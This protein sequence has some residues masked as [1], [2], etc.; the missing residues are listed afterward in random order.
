MANQ[1]TT[2]GSGAGGPLMVGV[3]G[4]RGIVGGSL[5]ADVVARYA[6]AWATMVQ[7][8]GA[9]GNGGEKASATSHQPSAEKRRSL[10]VVGRDGRAGGEAIERMAVDALT[11]AG[12]DVVRLGVAMTPT[13][14]V[15]VRARDAAGGMVVT[16]SHNPGEW[17]GL[18]P[19]TPEGSAPMPEVARELVA[20][21]ERGG[22][23][24]ADQPGRAQ[25][26]RGA[27]EFHVDR[28]LEA[29][30]RV[31]PLEKIRARRMRVVVDSVNASGSRGA[32]LLMDALGCVLTHI[33]CDETGVFP[34][35]PEP[36]EENLR[37]LCEAVRVEGADVGFAQDPDADRLAVV[38]GDGVYIGEEYTLVVA[39]L[40]V[41]E[42][43]SAAE[44]HRAV[45]AANLSTS[46][47]VDD[48]AARFEATVVRMPVGEANV[49]EGMRRTGAVIGGE[50]NGGVIWPEVGQI[51]DS[52]VG[53]GLTLALMARRGG[54]GGSLT[55]VVAEVPRYAIVKRKM[56]FEPGM[57]AR[58][59]AKL[60]EMFAGAA[61]DE[62]DGI[63]LDFDAPSGSG[64]AWL[65]A[66]KSNTEPIFRLIA[67]APTMADATAIV[68]RA[69]A[70]S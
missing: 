29:I 41:L 31:Y 51:R 34:H 5:T 65:H 20:R 50:G 27:T 1:N 56:A 70:G 15:A 45:L 44:A 4:L 49:V 48:V 43:M 58:I 36:T 3:S 52:L 38:D 13:V 46:R 10:V 19:I 63:R 23:V 67:E 54:G 8:A 57:D 62:Q 7:G 25:D 53:M 12:C 26:D 40:S 32:R 9:M 59:V 6:G 17:N 11:A 61:V 37:G 35:T 28:V 55:G 24:R 39:A 16:A 42:S 2:S 47:M 30:A 14:G 33:H 18:K 22:V 68:D 21:F 64:R 69:G 66:R 60:R